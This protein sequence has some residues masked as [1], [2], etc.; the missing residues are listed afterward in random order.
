MEQSGSSEQGGLL[1]NSHELLLTNLS[2]TVSVGLIDHL[3]DLVVSHVL[4][5]F[6]CYPLK[7]FERNFA[8]LIIIEESESLEHLLAGVALS[9]FLGHHV[10]EFWEVDH[11]TSIAVSIGNH[12]SD[13]LFLRL[14]AQS[15]H[16][17]LE[18][19][20]IDGPT[21]VSVEQVKGLLDFLFLLLSQLR[22]L[23]W[24]S[25]GSLFVA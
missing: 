11:A 12:F 18:L 24:S 21:A 5:E 14:E 2:I 16:G 3:L 6:F 8:G 7:I 17:N 1:H 4:S 23:L 10:Q 20:G 22:S 25:E 15:P 13:F 19:L 9:H